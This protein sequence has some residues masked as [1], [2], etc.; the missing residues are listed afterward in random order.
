MYR[1]KRVETFT[2]TGDW[3]RQR[4]W[5]GDELP[6]GQGG[7]ESCVRGHKRGRRQGDGGSDQ[8]RPDGRGRCSRLLHDQRGRAE[9]GQRT[10][11]SCGR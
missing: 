5:P 4:T 8:R 1:N 9:P 2:P 11:Q 10:G 3:R 7:C 6:A